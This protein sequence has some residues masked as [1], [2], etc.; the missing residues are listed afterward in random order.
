MELLARI[1][2]SAAWRLLRT[3][4]S[5]SDDTARGIREIYQKEAASLLGLRVASERTKEEQALMQ[6]FAQAYLNNISWE[7][8]GVRGLKTLA[9]LRRIGKSSADFSSMPPTLLARLDSIDSARSSRLKPVL[10]KRLADEFSTVWARS[11]LGLSGD[12]KVD[13]VSFS[14][15]LD[16]KVKSGQMGYSLKIEDSKR[17]NYEQIFGCPSGVWDFI[18]YGQE[19]GAADA[20]VPVIRA[21][22]DYYQAIRNEK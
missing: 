16:F 4:R 6:D 15:Q 17:F 7:D 3:M 1:P 20:L 12:G 10:M 9:T 22:V 18:E 19:E 8:W 11:S 2:N 21:S 13:T 5:F 14:I